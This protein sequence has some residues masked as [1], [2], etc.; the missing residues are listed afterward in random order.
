MLSENILL[1]FPKGHPLENRS[2]IRL[3]DTLKYPYV[4]PDENTC[5]GKIMTRFFEEHKMCYPANATVT[6]NSYVQCEL[7]AKGLGISFVPEKSW[8]Y[9]RNRNEII[10]RDM[11]DVVLRRNIFFQYHSNKYQNELMKK[12]G[13]FLKIYY[14]TIAL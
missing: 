6:N 12:F 2:R 1:A 9:A 8:V 10:L 4:L 5:M 7:V 14:K 3:E 13:E 11:D